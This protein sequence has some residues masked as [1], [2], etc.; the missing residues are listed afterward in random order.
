LSA[1]IRPLCRE[2]YAMH[3]V[4]V[5]RHLVH[6]LRRTLFA[7]EQWLEENGV[8]QQRLQVHGGTRPGTVAFA[9][10][11][12]SPQQARRFAEAFPPWLATVDSDTHRQRRSHIR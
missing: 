2:E 12:D 8:A 1:F 11:F 9:V 10:R 7:I 4:T 6:G 3:L 5:E